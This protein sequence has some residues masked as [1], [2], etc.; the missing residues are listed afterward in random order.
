MASVL[1]YD[2]FREEKADTVALDIVDITGGYTV[3]FLEDMGLLLRSDA[4]SFVTD[5]YP[6]VAILLV[7]RKMDV[8]A[9]AG[10]LDGIVQE[11]GDD[12]GH[13]G[14][15]YIGS[16]AFRCDADG[17][18]AGLCSLASM[19]NEAWWLC[20]SVVYDGYSIV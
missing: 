4:D 5:R 6:D 3:E 18:F 1:L 14:G 15:V 8:C 16:E 11:C 13:Q 10:V 12:A 7:G 20:N 19:I 2:G 17:Y 9:V